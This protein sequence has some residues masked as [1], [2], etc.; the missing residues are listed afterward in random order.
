MKLYK[1]IIINGQLELLTGIHIGDSKESVDIGGVDSPVVRR[2]DDNRPYIPGSSLKGKLR[3]LLDIAHGKTDTTRSPDHPIGKLFGALKPNK[4]TAGNPSR[5]IVRDA[6]LN[7]EKAKEI[8]DKG[9]TDMPYTEVKFENTIDRI[10]GIAL[11][12]RQFERVPAGAI[13]DVSFVINVI[14]DSDEEAVKAEMEMLD[15]FYAGIRLLEDDYLGG[16]GSR[17]YGQVKFTLNSPISKTSEQYLNA[18][19]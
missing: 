17:G 4:D 5:L 14:S 10:Q 9:F 1:K 6:D 13:F 2:K 8:Q 18:T 7:R 15:L 3:S 19:A 16:S 12:P 11:S